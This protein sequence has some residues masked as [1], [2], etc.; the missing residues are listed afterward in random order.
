VI[1]VTKISNTSQ[2][3]KFWKEILVENMFTLESLLFN[4]SMRNSDVP[5]VLLE[6]FNEKI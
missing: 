3:T 5:L 6:G 1:F 4:S 2:K